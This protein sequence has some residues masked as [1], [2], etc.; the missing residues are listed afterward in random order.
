M[1]ATSTAPSSLTDRA[2]P[3]LEHKCDRRRNASCTSSTFTVVACLEST[4][5]VQS[6]TRQQN[7]CLGSAPSTTTVNAVQRCCVF[8]A[9]IYCCSTIIN[10]TVLQYTVGCTCCSTDVTVHRCTVTSNFH[11]PSLVTSRLYTGFV[12]TQKSSSNCLPNNPD[13]VVCVVRPVAKRN[14]T[15][16]TLPLLHTAATN[17]IP[18]HSDTL[19]KVGVV[20]WVGE[21]KRSPGYS[22]KFLCTMTLF[23]TE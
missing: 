7:S 5:L 15:V 6:C 18:C 11:G 3:R 21:M 4:C 1:N 12:G 10:S 23:T 20:G 2:P 22:L 16:A 8:T 9:T 14:T 13:E 19:R 17:C